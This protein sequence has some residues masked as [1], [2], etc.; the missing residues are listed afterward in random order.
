MI[1][2]NIY[3]DDESGIL[4]KFTVQGHAGYA[5]RGHDIVCA[6]VSALTYATIEALQSRFRVDVNECEGFISCRIIMPDSASN[7]LVKAFK[8]GARMLS[9]QYTDYV[10]LHRHYL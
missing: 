10:N 5:A 3:E 2:I 4:T 8:E 6:A 1:S 9:Q 7:L